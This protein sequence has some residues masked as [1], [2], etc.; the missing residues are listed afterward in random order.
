MF[1]VKYQ[2]RDKQVHGTL[3]ACR[4]YAFCFLQKRMVGRGVGHEEI[5]TKGSKDNQCTWPQK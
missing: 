1:T 2:H 3:V 4:M 5:F